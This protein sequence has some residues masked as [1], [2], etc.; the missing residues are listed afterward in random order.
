MAWWIGLLMLH[1]ILF[2]VLRQATPPPRQAFNGGPCKQHIAPTTYHVSLWSNH[3]VWV[4]TACRRGEMEM[5]HQGQQD[6]LIDISIASTVWVWGELQGKWGQ[7]S[8]GPWQPGEWSCTL[9]GWSSS[10]NSLFLDGNRLKR[11]C[12]G[13]VGYP[14]MRMALWARQVS[15]M[16]WGE[17]RADVGATCDRLS[18]SHDVLKALREG[19]CAGATTPWCSLIGCCRSCPVEGA[20]AY[21][22]QSACSDA[23]VSI[24]SQHTLC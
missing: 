9:L 13:W 20:H 24:R 1:L 8:L 12:D 15:Y 5:K 2:E 21:G 3:S 11:L 18:C 4:A 16:S 6:N 19:Y 22:D 10:W 23:Q 17:E 7:G 14:M